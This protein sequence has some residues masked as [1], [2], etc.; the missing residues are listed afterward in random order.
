MSQLTVY[1]ASA[2]SGKTYKL[3]QEYL[4]LLF[5]YPDNYKHILALTFTNKAAGEMKERIISELA[6]LARNEESTYLKDIESHF[7]LSRSEIQTKASNL[8]QNILHD[9]SKF[10][11]G[12]ID[13]FFQKVFRVFLKELRLKLGYN[14]EF[15]TEK[16]LTVAIDNI[17]QTIT[18][19]VTLRRWLSDFA[20]Q[21]L[22]EGRTWN[23]KK[24][25]QS[26]GQEV[27]KEGYRLRSSDDKENAKD[28]EKLRVYI[29]YLYKYKIDLQ[30][31]LKSIGE[32]AL[33][34]IALKGLVVEDFFKG[35]M[36]PAGYFLKLSQENFTIPSKTVLEGID[37]PE[38]WHIQKTEKAPAIVELVTSYLNDELKKAYKYVVD[39]RS[40]KVVQE[41]IYT[42]GL[43]RDISDQIVTISQEQDQFII[44]NITKL[45]YS[46][47]KGN[48]VPF[49]Y[50]KLG[51]YFN[52]IM[53]DEFQDTS[54]MQWQN[55]KP[56]V[57]DNLAQ[58]Y[59][60]LVIG[61][62]KQAIYR[63]RNSDWTIM[64]KELHRDFKSKGI[65]QEVLDYN[66]RSQK[67]IIQFNNSL[68]NCAALNLEHEFQ[69]E[70]NTYVGLQKI[71]DIHIDIKSLYQDVIQELP[72]NKM[73]NTEGYVKI[74]KVKG[75]KKGD[76]YTKI[77]SEIP[78]LIE[79]L[80]DHKYNAGDIAILVREKTDGQFVSDYL[81]DYK[82]NKGNTVKYNYDFVS[83]ET[84]L[85]NAS[86]VVRLLVAIFR[87][88]ID[89]MNKPNR[90][91]VRYLIA[92]IR[93]E[94]TSKEELHPL[95][96]QSHDEGEDLL[97]FLT[98]VD[99]K[100]LSLLSPYE[101]VERIVEVLQLNQLS[102]ELPYLE[103]FL[104]HINT[105]TKDNMVTIHSIIEWWDEYGK[106]L[107]VQ[108]SDMQDA[109]Q[110]LT[111]HKAK[112]LEFKAVIVPFCDWNLDNKASIIWC[113]PDSSPLNQIK[114]LPL[115]YKQE[116]K[117]TSFAKAYYEEKQKAYIDNLNLL[118]V[119]FTRAQEVLFVFLPETKSSNKGKNVSRLIEKSFEMEYDFSDNQTHMISLKELWK[120]NEGVFELGRLIDNIDEYTDV[121]TK[122]SLL[123]HTS[124]SIENRLAL[125]YTA[126]DYIK[127]G[128]DLF[129][130]RINYGKTMHELFA[131]IKALD[132]I[133]EV[134][135]S[136][137]MEGRI[138]ENER[139]IIKKK[140]DKVFKNELVKSW[141]Q[142]GIKVKTESGIVIRGGK[143]RRPD[144]V[145]MDENVTTVV[146]YKFGQKAESSHIKQVKEYMAHIAE[147]KYKN[148]KGYV[149]Y[150]DQNH[151]VEC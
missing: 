105:L 80:Q 122:F 139:K 25:I 93:E 57:D 130:S 95:F 65:K 71:N 90:A 112:G 19:N 56:L 119:T 151:I 24:E 140:V 128:R 15:D 74:E 44:N 48:E 117:N 35:K 101:S 31:K 79:K 121:R 116:L 145:M 26:L 69:E 102:N 67:R 20:L 100:Q 125:R 28:K 107:P 34:R 11:I 2:G 94:L 52:H 55:L 49:I 81:L 87:Y 53:I 40:V 23:L 84:L 131:R 1:K 149:W 126:V 50:E 127:E 45:L 143:L 8:L 129:S 77:V 104:D 7:R 3:T 147:M 86:K 41:D 37:T 103:A 62:T 6:K 106:K 29:S 85:L 60:A 148:I 18:E 136:F 141:F 96:F 97:N 13:S 111:I 78:K 99:S 83:N 30:N 98:G 75:D 47:I 91:L 88:I 82:Q 17:F 70:L 33:N 21:N 43:L 134:L 64:A 9:F 59:N 22:N 144:R 137:V 10:S 114:R 142:P 92:Q 42:L 120:R 118:Y 36:G 150:V 38:N 46:I 61:D 4:F 146:D 39:L 12:T 66:W 51:N 54:R 124:E 113:E 133:Q 110:I 138:N 68:F 16:V 72:P 108:F 132:D 135:N 73:N 115:T 123:E 109:I 5:S 14:L 89:P 27:F 32:K 76:T 58:N 63:W